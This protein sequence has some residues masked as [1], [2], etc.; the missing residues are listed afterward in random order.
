[1]DAIARET[2][3]ATAREVIAIRHLSKTY[4]GA[5]SGVVALSDI[6]CA[7]ADG[8]FLSIVGPSG[9]GKSTLLKILAGLLQAS[10]GQALLNGSPIQG[11][12]KDIGVVFQ[13]PVLFPWRSVLG[14]V[15][16]PVDV[17]QLG[18]D[19][20]TA[21]A[22]DLLKLVGLDGFEH[23]YP[24]E[25]SGGMQ[26]RVALVRA[27]IHDPALLLMDEPFGALDA[28]TR[29]QMNVELQ[30]IWME[31]RKTVVFITHS[32]SE[33]V[34]LGDRVMVMTPRPGKIG[35]LFAVDLPRP[36]ALDVMTTEK[37]GVY[38]RRIRQS[39]NAGGGLE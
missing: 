32:T 35:D 27:L 2:A 26:Q 17:Q 4:G 13:S 9:C 12:R 15:L 30:R 34:F 8:E 10:G 24:W 37:F 22:M 21:R 16:L 11:A 14:N 1:L 5:G 18:R 19:K 31:R 28:M 7:V 20:M 25:L 33:A 6:D 29:E 23:R 39:L 38:V 3:P 36:R